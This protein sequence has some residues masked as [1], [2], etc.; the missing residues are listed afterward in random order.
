MVEVYLI[1]FIGS[2]VVLLHL[3]WLNEGS[4][5]LV[6]GLAGMAAGHC[7]ERGVHGRAVGGGADDI[8]VGEIRAL[9]WSYGR[10]ALIAGGLSWV[11]GNINF[12]FRGSSYL[13]GSDECNRSRSSLQ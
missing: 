7:I 9:H 2:S 1:L 4:A 10:W 12:E 5:L 11:P 13:Q 6:M 3:G 8:D